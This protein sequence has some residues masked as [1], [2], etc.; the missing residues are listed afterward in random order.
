MNY[1]KFYEEETGET[2]PEGYEI[3]HIDHDR[4]NNDIDNL[5][6]LPKKLHRRYHYYR[7]KLLSDLDR[8]PIEEII[9]FN[10]TFGDIVFYHCHKTVEILSKYI[11]ICRTVSGFI[12]KRDIMIY[13]SIENFIEYQI[14]KT[15]L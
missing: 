15:R 13:G 8:M 14:R 12:V 3:H 4:K 7:N 6:A 10:T 1:R 11:E 2:I 9:P 5:V